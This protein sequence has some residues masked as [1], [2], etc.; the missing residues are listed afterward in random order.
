MAKYDLP[1]QYVWEYGK[2]SELKLKG[3]GRT[4][5]GTLNYT[6]TSSNA[7]YSSATGEAGLLTILQTALADYII[8]ASDFNSYQTQITLAN[9]SITDIE[10][11]V[12]TVT[13]NVT[14]VTNNLSTHTGTATIHRNITAGTTD[15]TG[16]SNGDIYIKY[17]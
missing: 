1:D 13:N 6:S 14:T 5:T 11:D 8:T 3:T 7:S 4:T 16:G 15:P 17:E 12:T 10:G 9:T 2:Y